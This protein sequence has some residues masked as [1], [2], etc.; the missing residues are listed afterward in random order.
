MGLLMRALAAG[1]IERAIWRSV[2]RK[3]TSV[4]IEADDILKP[5]V[6]SNPP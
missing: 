6:A 2:N 4:V 5:G 3:G 1:G